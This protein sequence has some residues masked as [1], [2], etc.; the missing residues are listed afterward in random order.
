M[1]TIDLKII[2]QGMDSI[3]LFKSVSFSAAKPKLLYAWLRNWFNLLSDHAFHIVYIFI[4]MPKVHVNV[5]YLENMLVVF[6]R[7]FE[8]RRPSTGNFHDPISD[9]VNDTFMF[10]HDRESHRSLPRFNFP[11]FDG[12]NPQL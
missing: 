5:L 3:F 1:F 9:C 2:Y 10:E 4:S 8:R 12:D 11:L 7:T 6:L